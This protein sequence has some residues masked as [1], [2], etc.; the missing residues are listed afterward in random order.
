[1]LFG[2]GATVV[3]V[4]RRCQA[5]RQAAERQAAAFRLLSVHLPWLSP[6]RIWYD[7]LT[8]ESLNSSM[9]PATRASGGCGQW[10]QPFT[11]HYTLPSLLSAQIRKHEAEQPSRAVGQSS[12]IDE[13]GV[14][15]VSVKLATSDLRSFDAVVRR[16]K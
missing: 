8:K 16:P 12:M 14:S 4:R 13:S 10:V 2:C 5:E 6:A 7:G 3:E 11:V 9:P 1:M 15:Q